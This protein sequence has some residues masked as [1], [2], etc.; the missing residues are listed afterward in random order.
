MP[1]P[2]FYRL[3]EERQK[4]ILQAAFEEF[5][6]NPL[7]EASVGNITKKLSLSRA[8]F[9]KY[10]NDLEEVYTYIYQR[11]AWD[12]HDLLLQSLE[13]AEGIFFEGMTR[14]A[15]KM[16][17]QFFEPTYR[18]FYRNLLVK[19]D[20]HL[21]SQMEKDSNTPKM[22]YKQFLQEVI[23]V[24]DWE[25]IAVEEHELLAFLDFIKEI[26]HELFMKSFLREWTE[27]QTFAAIHQR[28]NWLKRGILK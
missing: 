8:S 22:D 20:Y 27:E 10:F 12:P 1:K 21:F 25:E 18:A 23:E 9:Y 7:Q 5:S 2:T 6:T 28:L 4:E 26:F 13:E 14:Y 11:I 24:I 17:N 15:K 16:A 3:P 19:M